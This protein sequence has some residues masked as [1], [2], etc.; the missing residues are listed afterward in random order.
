MQNFLTFQIFLVQEWIIYVL[1]EYICKLG[2]IKT[3]YLERN[4]IETM[5][6]KRMKAT[7]AMN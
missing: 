6:N 7:H 4:T 5:N 3:E 1:K 2:Q